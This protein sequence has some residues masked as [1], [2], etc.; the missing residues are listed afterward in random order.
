MISVNIIIFN[1]R[2]KKRPNEVISFP[3]KRKRSSE[4][5]GKLIEKHIGV[6]PVERF[7]S[8]SITLFLFIFIQGPS[9]TPKLAL[10]FIK[11]YVPGTSAAPTGTSNGESI[12]VEDVATTDGGASGA[13]GTAPIEKSNEKDSEDAAVMSTN[14]AED[15]DITIEAAEPLVTT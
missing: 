13:A 2:H 14:G 11:S 3:P 5:K 9:E 12:Q 4:G 1:S 6:K 8:V 10:E 15:K 7:C